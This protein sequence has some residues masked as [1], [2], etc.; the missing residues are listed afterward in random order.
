[1]NNC[2]GADVPVEPC[3]SVNLQVHP[4]GDINGK[5]IGSLIYMNMLPQQAPPILAVTNDM[6]YPYPSQV[7]LPIFALPESD[8]YHFFFVRRS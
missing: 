4:P 3:D 2:I 5:Y 1:V 7:I 8:A 6:M